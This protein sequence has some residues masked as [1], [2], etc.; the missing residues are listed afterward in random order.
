MPCPDGRYTTDAFNTAMET[1][2]LWEAFVCP[3]GGPLGTFVVG[4]F[5]YSATALNIFIRTGSWIMPLILV[6]ILGGTVLAQT[7]GI[8]ST[9]AGLIV[10][11]V[12]PLVISGLVF[13]LDV[14]T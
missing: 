14:R 5:L 10:L 12:P 7:V 2:D 3:Y 13:L 8:I 6:L 1:F 11:I 9:F 4:T